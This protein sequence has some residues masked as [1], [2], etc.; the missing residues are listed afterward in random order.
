VPFK[1][2]K[3]VSALKISYIAVVGYKVE[4]GSLARVLQSIENNVDGIDIEGF[5][6]T[7]S[8]SQV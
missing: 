3:L 4:D 5:Y 8:I 2:A 7:T 6:T 1:K